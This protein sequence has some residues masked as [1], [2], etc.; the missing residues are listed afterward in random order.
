MPV[1]RHHPFGRAGHPPAFWLIYVLSVIFTFHTLLVAYGNSSYMER[2]TTPEVIGMLYSIG[3]SLSVFAFLFLARVLRK[4]GNV[5]LTIT[6][7]VLEILALLFIGLA[8]G[9]GITIIA[10]VA[11][12]TINPLLY[13]SIDIFSESL[14]GSNE[15]STGSKRGLALSLMSL[16]SS[17]GA[18]T[19]GLLV[20]DDESQLYRIYFVAAAVFL[21]FIG[22]VQIHFKSFVDPE[23]RELKVLEAMHDFWV[24]RNLRY[25]FLAYLILQ[26]FF[27]WMIIYVPLYLA[28]VVGLSWEAIGSIISV[29][30]LAYVFF[31]YPIGIIADKYI[32]EKEMMIAGFV[33]LMMSAI[34]ISLIQTAVIVS[35]MIVMFVSRIGASLVETTSESYFFKHT[36][37]SDANVISFFRLT[38]PLAVVM[39]SLLGSATLLFL[40]FQNIFFVLAAVM[41]P[42]LLCALQIKDT[43]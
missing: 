14:I 4:V 7:A 2:F 12:L 26:V 38:N 27:S 41:L 42:G 32:G 36:A 6:L 15:S 31:E 34:S 33:I 21:L 37:G 10:F 35:W 16:A 9:P 43:K 28:T 23:Y 1:Y 8:L 24:N 30:L 40:P 39:G 3:A 11:F 19:L 20:G 29:G 13:M 18:L 5:R 25:V 17:T 22:L